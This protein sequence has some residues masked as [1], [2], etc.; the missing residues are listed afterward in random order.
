MMRIYGFAMQAPVEGEEA[1][2]VRKAMAI[3]DIVDT[4]MHCLVNTK[5]AK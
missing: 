4:G 2:P 5:K 1:A 3:V